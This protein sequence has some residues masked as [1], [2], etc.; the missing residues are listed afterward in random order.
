MTRVKSQFANVFN[1]RALGI[2]KALV[3]SGILLATALA[4]RGLGTGSPAM[5][6]SGTSSIANVFPHR[7]V[8]LPPHAKEFYMATL[9]VDSLALK[10]VESGL[11]IR[12]S[13]RVV[14]PEKAG[15]LN[16]KK[17]SPYLL[18]ELTHRALVIPTLEKVG[19]LR[20]TGTPEV[21]RTYWMLFSNKG[22]FVKSG[23]R[24]S[25]VIGKSRID[26]LMVQ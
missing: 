13:Y 10:A 14:N 21:G 9:G 1:H 22:N 8:E 17:I 4:Q 7:P 11:M 20:Q 6:R 25:V 18:E 24:A 26:G 16:D 12:F 19:Q 2:G 23:S 15:T 3:A 5:A